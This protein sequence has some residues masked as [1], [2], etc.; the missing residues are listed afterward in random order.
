[1]VTTRR[2]SPR[3]AVQEAAPAA[4]AVAARLPRRDLTGRA[5]ELLRNDVLDGRIQPGEALFEVHL[6]QR[7]GMSR[8]P[9]REA[10]KLLAHQGYLDELPS[11]GYALP[12]RSL[13]DLREFFE[14][15]EVLE[16]AA[17]RYAAL[18]ATPQELQ[19][20]KRLCKAYEAETHLVRWNR[21]GGEFHD[22]IIAAS[23][24]RRLQSTLEALNAHIQ[25]S[26]RPVVQTTPQ[27]RSTSIADHHAILEA[28]TVRD[29]EAAHRAAAEHVR[30]SFAA[31]L[32]AFHP[33]E[34]DPPTRG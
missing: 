27:W 17:T 13:N 28:L 16:A 26:R 20:L 30:R 11:R 4:G 34:F 7:L 1:L 29:A 9:V 3:L 8:T 22:L 6:A 2:P 18:R 31:T 24:N 32:Q 21:L 19:T 5:Y 25:L 33:R 12:R 10:L 23:H 14:L 15:R